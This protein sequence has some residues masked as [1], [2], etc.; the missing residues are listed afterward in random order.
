VNWLAGVGARLVRF[1]AGAS[2]RLVELDWAWRRHRTWLAVLAFLVV[3]GVL[4]VSFNPGTPDP[5]RAEVERTAELL[6]R[7]FAGGVSKLSPSYVR[8]FDGIEDQHLVGTVARISS[9]GSCWGFTVR[10]PD[11]WLSDGTGSVEVGPT[12]ELDTSWC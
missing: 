5:V 2:A 10:V 6:R 1:L 3:A 12:G 9:T 7:D 11:T 4:G 8:N